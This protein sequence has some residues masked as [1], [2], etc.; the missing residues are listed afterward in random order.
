MRDD[1]WP[2]KTIKPDSDILRPNKSEKLLLERRK[3][4]KF[5]DLTS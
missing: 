4:K 5:N 3:R 2:F 1:N